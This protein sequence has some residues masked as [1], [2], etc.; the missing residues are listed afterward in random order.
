MD[1]LYFKRPAFIFNKPTAT[2]FCFPFS[3]CLG[4]Y[5]YKAYLKQ[6]T[7][8]CTKER[9]KWKERDVCVGATVNAGRSGVC[10]RCYYADTES[11]YIILAVCGV[12]ELTITRQAHCQVQTTGDKCEG[13]ISL[14]KFPPVSTIPRTRTILPST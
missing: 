8:V 2:L 6:T 10:C 3:K 4:P 9:V 11:L 14:K 1:Y 7:Q 5:W 13:D 12:L